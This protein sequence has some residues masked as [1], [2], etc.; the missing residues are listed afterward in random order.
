MIQAHKNY[1]GIDN[2][3]TT[4]G[5]EFLYPNGFA[6]KKTKVK[7]WQ[8]CGKMCFYKSNDLTTSCGSF[9]YDKSTKTC[10]LMDSGPAVEEEDGI[11]WCAGVKNWYTGY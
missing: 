11:V 10:Y 2:V 9:T 7:T 1:K 8:E 6:E 5:G 3:V 4:E